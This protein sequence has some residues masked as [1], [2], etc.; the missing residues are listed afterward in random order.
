MTA[1]SA[2][3]AIGMLAA[4]P[5]AASRANARASMMRVGGKPPSKV[6]LDNT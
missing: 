5:A 1:V 3:I 4:C 2:P 6:Q